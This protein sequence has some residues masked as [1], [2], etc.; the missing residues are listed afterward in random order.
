[1]SELAWTREA[2]TSLRDIY[3]F[4]A[5][6]RPTTAR[7]TLDS[8]LAR[9]QSLAEFPNHGQPYA[10]NPAVRVL[11]YG[12]F[13]IAYLPSPGRVTILGIFHGLMFLPLD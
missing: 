9:A 11:A 8:L 6:D 10:Y 3:G 12:Q 13:Q 7:R 5:R 1:M 2:K 4:I